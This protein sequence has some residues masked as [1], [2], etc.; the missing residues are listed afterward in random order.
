MFDLLQHEPS[1][2]GGLRSSGETWAWNLT[3]AKLRPYRGID[4]GKAYLAAI[5]ALV[6]IPAFSTAP[7]EPSPL[8]L[9]EAFDH[10]DLAWRLQT[11]QRLIHVPG[12]ASWRV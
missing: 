10:L 9:A 4:T 12:P 8:E 6:G 7:R 3:R 1:T 2:W 11:S 5:E